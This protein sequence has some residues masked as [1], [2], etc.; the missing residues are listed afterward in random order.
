MGIHD[1]C[2]IHEEPYRICGC[3]ENSDCKCKKEG[4]VALECRGP[5]TCYENWQNRTYADEEEEFV[6]GMHEPDYDLARDMERGK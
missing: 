6:F 4:T 1:A 2:P 3:I 5:N